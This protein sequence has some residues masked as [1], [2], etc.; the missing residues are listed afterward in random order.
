MD[1]GHNYQDSHTAEDV[2][3]GPTT[4]SFGDSNA[5][6][7]ILIVVVPSTAMLWFIAGCDGVKSIVYHN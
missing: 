6:Q 5:T 7:S 4:K 1:V 3:I 2:G